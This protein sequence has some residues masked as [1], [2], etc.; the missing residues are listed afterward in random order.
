MAFEMAVFD[1]DPCPLVTLGDEADLDLAGL[2]EIRLDL[3]L[4]A[5]VPADHD[6]VGRVVGE[7]A[8]PTALAPVDAPVVH[9]TAHARFE[10][11]L[12]DLDAEQ[13]VFAWLDAI[14]LLGEDAER[15]VDRRIHDDLR[16]NARGF[17]SFEH[18]INAPS[19]SALPLVA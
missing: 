5:D 13:V 2:L 9:V 18:L 14:E 16:V 19:S 12:G 1:L 3:P 8:R 6:S 15:L 7:N 10:H 11:R 17:D 4:R